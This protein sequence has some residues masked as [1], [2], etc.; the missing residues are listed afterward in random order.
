MSTLY[1]IDVSTGDLSQPVISGARH[2]S[3][4]N[5]SHL[6]RQL[7]GGQ[8][9][10]PATVTIRNSAVKASASIT[11]ASVADSD[12]ITIN[13]VVFTAQDASP[14]ANEYL[15]TGTNTQDAAA[16][17]AAINASTT[18]GIVGIVTA[19]SSGAVLTISAAV[20]GKIGNAISIAT[21]DGTTLAI[22][23]GVSKLAGGTET[24]VS[25]TF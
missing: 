3:A 18:A 2:L 12:T 17:A 22:T 24:S 6:F 7:A 10:C 20:P 16:A 23:S 21:S 4:L 8:N 25:F 11:F 1:S 19:S 5:L 13:G 9:S 14:G 15:Q